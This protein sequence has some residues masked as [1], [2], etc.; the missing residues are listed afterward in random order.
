MRSILASNFTKNI[1]RTAKSTCSFPGYSYCSN[2]INNLYSSQC[3]NLD[4]T[5]AYAIYPPVRV[6]DMN[7]AVTEDV[8]VISG[9]CY[10]ISGITAYSF[11]YPATASVE[12]PVGQIDIKLD[13]YFVSKQNAE[14][15][16]KLDYDVKLDSN[17]NPVGSGEVNQFY[18]VN[19][20]NFV[21]E[22]DVGDTPLDC[23]VLPESA[24]CLS[25]NRKKITAMA[26]VFFLNP[27]TKIME[28]VQAGK[29]EYTGSDS[30]TI[31]IS[32]ED[33]GDIPQKTWKIVPNKLYTKDTP[34]DDLPGNGLSAGA[35]AGIVIACVVVVGI[36][37]FCIIWF[38][39]LKKS[40]ASGKKDEEPEV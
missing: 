3:I 1:S 37:V 10:L 31:T 12:Q 29:T 40:C 30:L 19:I 28:E 34:D 2:Q 4:E 11:I 39:V 9:G 20:N 25:K 13:V 16:L 32:G 24:G 18:V 27:E 5:E 7:G 23:L 14:L 26:G 21:A 36:A 35:I 17:Y 15:N 8:Y 22:A 33:P 6:E 38:V